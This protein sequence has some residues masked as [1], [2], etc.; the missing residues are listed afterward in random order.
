M[1]R[2][3]SGISQ[4]P[5]VSLN[6]LLV[7][8]RW[9][10]WFSEPAGPTVWCSGLQTLWPLAGSEGQ[11]DTVWWW[12][13]DDLG[14]KTNAPS[15]TNTYPDSVWAVSVSY[16]WRGAASV[17]RLRRWCKRRSVDL[18]HKRAA[19]RH[20]RSCR[21]SAGRPAS[22]S[23]AQEETIINIRIYLQSGQRIMAATNS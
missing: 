1:N 23:T 12:S 8:C 20:T 2:H 19:G 11:T 3:E 9:T 6:V 18:Q 13:G 5:S 21:R 15:L 17:R 14:E 4:A 22:T 10:R 16:R 7:T